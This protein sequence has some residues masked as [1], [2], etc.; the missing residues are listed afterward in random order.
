MDEPPLVRGRPRSFVTSEWWKSGERDQIDLLRSFD[1][2]GTTTTPPTPSSSSDDTTH[3]PSSSSSRTADRSFDPSI[4]MGRR[5]HTPRV[6]LLLSNHRTAA[7]RSRRRGGARRGSAPGASCR[8]MS[9]H[10]RIAMSRAPCDG[11]GCGT[12]KQRNGAVRRAV[13]AA[14]R[15]PVVGSRGA[16]ARRGRDAA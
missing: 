10:G 12:S 5:H 6:L 2:H 8:V 9:C 7:P 15:A 16:S 3:T 11:M 1:P 13:A 14:S 4:L